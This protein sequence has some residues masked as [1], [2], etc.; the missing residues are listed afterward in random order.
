M[1]RGPAVTDEG[2]KS[3]IEEYNVYL[4]LK[5]VSN[6]KAFAVDQL[7][8]NADGLI[9]AIV[10]DGADGQVLMLAYM[11]REALERTLATGQTWFYS[12]SRKQ[13]WHKGETSGNVQLVRAIYTDCDQ[14]TLVVQVKQTGAGACHEGDYT[15][16]HYAVADTEGKAW[17][18]SEHDAVKPHERK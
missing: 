3:A 4:R 16:F 10:Q 1:H 18:P 12:R 6:M 5:K 13:L 11:N 7:K 9:P 2:L 15:C 17:R 14:D 8:Y